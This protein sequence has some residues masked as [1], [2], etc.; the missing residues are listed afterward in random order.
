MKR[1]S[2]NSHTEK[3]IGLKKKDGVMVKSIE[4]GNNF[5]PYFPL[6]LHNML[7]SS[8]MLLIFSEA[9]RLFWE[10]EEKYVAQY[11]SEFE[12]YKGNIELYIVEDANHIFSFQ[13]WQETMMTKAYEWLAANY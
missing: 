2:N 6:A 8:K 11:K 7:S 3:H 1:K 10:F 13:K 4:S 5:N 12:H 9:D